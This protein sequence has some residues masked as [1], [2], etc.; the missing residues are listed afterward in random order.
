MTSLVI[1]SYPFQSDAGVSYHNAAFLFRPVSMPSLRRSCDPCVSAKRRC[2]LKTPRCAPCMDRDITCSY[3]NRPA[4]AT[5]GRQTTWQETFRQARQLHVVGNGSPLSVLAFEQGPLFG[6]WTQ[7]PKVVRLFS[8]I[9]IQQQL[10]ILKTFVINFAQHG[11]A[12][13]LHSC[14]YD[15]RLPLP[16]QYVW[17]ICASSGSKEGLFSNLHAENVHAQASEMLRS[18]A[19]AESFL[20]LLSHIQAAALLRIICL[21]Q[22]QGNYSEEDT[23]RDEETFWELALILYIRAPAKLPSTLSPWRAWLLAESVRRTILV[24]YIIMA[25]HSVLRRGYVVH[26]LCVEALPFDMRAPLWDADTAA[27]W[28]AAAAA[29]HEPSL[30]SLREFAALQAQAQSGPSL[31]TLVLLSFR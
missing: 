31:E 21:F 5:S 4:G 12:S 25:V 15:T 17:G 3:I 22:D 24:C 29:S 30:V 11:A 27:E 19:R 18:A 26:M 2:D 14:L 9:T 10:T 16:L 7:I 28:E 8:P 13:F 1:I 20:E 23:R 6:L